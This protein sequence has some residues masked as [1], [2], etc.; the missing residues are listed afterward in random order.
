MGLTSS[1]LIGRSA[2]QASQYALQVTGNNIANVGTAGYHRQRAEF[3][4]Q[5]GQQFGNAF[6]GRGVNIGDVRRLVDPA[7]Q[8]RLRS[9]ISQEQGAG[10][11]RQ[12]LD[13]IETLTNELSG[14]DVSSELSKFFN[15]FSE[16]ANNPGSPALRSTVVETGAGLAAKLRGLRSNLVEA[17]ATAQRQIGD[18]VSRADQLLTQI[19]QLNQQV[20][21]AEGGKATPSGGGQNGNLRDQRD[22]LIDE[23]SGLL[24]VTVVER[25]SGAA[26]ILL[27]STPLVLGGT[28]RGLEV[29]VRQEAT[30]P[31]PRLVIRDGNEDITATGGVIGALFAGRSGA[32]QRTI[33]DLDRVSSALIFNVN[34]LHSSGRPPGRITDT[35]GTLI[36]GAQ[37]QARAL[38]DPANTTFSALPFKV[39]SGSFNVT[40]T[41]SSGNKVT[42]TIRVDLDGIR[43]DGT[44][45]FTDDTTMQSLASQ[46]SAVSPNLQA[47]ITAGGQLRLRTDNG[48]DVSF[49]S[50]TSGALAAFGVNTFFQGKDASDID[51]RAQLRSDPSQL[52]IGLGAGTNETALAIA[53]LRTRKLDDL[54]GSTIAEAWAS[55]V[56]ATAASASSAK[57]RQ[58]SL[59][60]VRQSLEAQQQAV[61]G[62]SLDE[63]SINLLLYQQQ[64]QGAARFI[65]V[66]NDLTQV[67]LGLVR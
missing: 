63:E 6:Y 47:Q 32:V 13:Q 41:D 53:G 17:R 5:R 4:P 36:V 56:D 65:G 3:D 57:A 39:T 67:L 51:V 62:V 21:A 33:N 43:N 18:N 28:S 15:A 20:V 42:R 14:T 12:L 30:G 35:T 45:G 50:D 37:D 55:S 66:V 26:D 1:L 58:D 48:Y 9:T 44:P 40:V 11:D 52:S 54:G 64:Y 27:N 61:S 23:L 46:L 24:D 16:L 8:A 59:A 38:N 25:E 10:I 19:A 49:D 29:Q 7:L 31:E 34:K 22:R 2:L 60:S